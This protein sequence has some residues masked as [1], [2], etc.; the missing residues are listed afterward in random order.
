VVV[1]CAIDR[2]L[3]DG[4]A[5]GGRAAAREVMDR[6]P[7]ITP[8]LKLAIVAAVEAGVDRAMDRL[9]KKPN[10]WFSSIISSIGLVLIYIFGHRY[11]WVRAAI[12][13]LKGKP[14]QVHSSVPVDNQRYYGSNEALHS[15][16]GGEEKEIK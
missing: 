11:A 13:I 7:E 15:E 16:P 9:A 6:F 12:D 2:A 3:R 1:G 4:L 5:E 14:E 10:G 8:E